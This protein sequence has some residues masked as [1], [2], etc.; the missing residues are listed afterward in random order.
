MR[1]KRR[2]V[3]AGEEPVPCL[4]AVKLWSVILF[5]IESADPQRAGTVILNGSNFIAGQR[6]CGQR[7]M[8]QNREIKSVETIQ[9]V[10]GSKP[11]KAGTILQDA[12]HYALRKPLFDREGFKGEAV[13]LAVPRGAEANREKQ[14][15]ENCIRRVIVA[16]APPAPAIFLAELLPHTKPL[17]MLTRARNGRL[18]CGMTCRQAHRCA[19]LQGITRQLAGVATRSIIESPVIPK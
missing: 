2:H 17:H 9:A 6:V 7:I 11:E 4:F 1:R 16:G 3:Q 13:R 12:E 10:F 18:A 5:F 14:G 8:L 19:E 15:A